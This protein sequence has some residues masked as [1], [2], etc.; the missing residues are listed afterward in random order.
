MWDMFK[1]E[2]QRFRIWAIAYAVLQLVILGFMT[3]V[4]DLAQQPRLVYE[5]LAGVYAVTGLLLG[6]YQM[7]GYRKPNTWMNL[8]HRPI[9]HGKL[10]AVLVG[11]G[12][13]QL[14]VAVVL[15]LWLLAGW[16]EFMTARVVDHRHLLLGVS[17]WLIAVCAYL[18]GAYAMLANRRYGYSGIALL[19]WLVFSQATGLGAIAVQLITL[20]MLA[21]MVWVAF[22]PD[23]GAAPHTLP[24]TFF[25][26][27]PLQLAMWLALVMVGFGIEFLWI[28]QGSHPNNA[29]VPAAGG[30]K[31]SENAEGKDLMVMGLRGSRDPQAPLWREQAQ[32]SEVFSFGPG[33]R[34]TPVRNELVNIVPMEFDDEQHRIRWVFSHDRM[35]LEGYSLVDYRSV[36][37]L[38]VEGDAPFPEPVMPGP[39]NSLIGTTRVYQYDSDQK[40]VVPRLRLPAGERIT[41]YDRVGDDLA[42]LSD[43]AV[44]FYDGRD[45]AASDGMLTPRQR[46]AIPGKVGDLYRADAIELLD[47]YLV[48]FLFSRSAHNAE[49][50][51]PYQQ[52]TRIDDQ[53]NAMPIMR[54]DLKSGFPAL[55]R[56]QNWFPAPVIYELQR[57]ARRLFAGYQITDDTARPPVPRQVAVIA[58]VL[59]LLSLLGAVWWTRKTDLSMP[60]RIAW[61]VACGVLSLPA[62]MSLRLIHP[63]R[64]VLQPQLV[65]QPALA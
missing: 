47:G 10:A 5:V 17:A 12:A 1:A 11:A 19:S 38:G 14:A 55:W 32:I 9:P 57:A 34:A 7:G 41:G 23:L 30:E 25:T 2:M 16:Q 26:A 45:L 42:L 39:E 43:R 40:R 59:M 33:L 8:L 54:R 65:A 63:R 28:A 31:E 53:G 24:R 60:A 58:G 22:K 64:E 48:S 49:G 3:R 29:P 4:V 6:L 50:A 46:L 35:R 56:Y 27:V 20:A 61:I 52:M 18:A 15:P 62:L 51:L 44:Y 37:E 13:L 21:G 36:G